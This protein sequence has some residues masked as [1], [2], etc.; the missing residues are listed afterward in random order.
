MDDPP[1]IVHAVD[2][3]PAPLGAVVTFIAGRLGLRPPPKIQPEVT[4]GK[5][6]DGTLLMT[7]LGSLRHPTFQSGY[8][9]LT[10]ARSTEE[11]SV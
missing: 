4:S 10:A 9:D 5:I 8:G 11:E 6:L 2:Q 7:L 1:D 3:A